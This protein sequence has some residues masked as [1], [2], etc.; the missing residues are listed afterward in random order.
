MSPF[1]EKEPGSAGRPV[2]RIGAKL[3]L[4]FVTLGLCLVLLELAARLLLPWSNPRVQI[5]YQRTT[6]GI[7]LGPRNQTVRL[8]TPKGDY[9]LLLHFNEDGFRD[10]KNLRE[11][12]E[13]DWFALGDSYTLGVGV[14][15]AERFSNLLEE[16]FKT[17]GPALSGAR[18]FNIAIPDNIIGYQRLLKYAE[19][20]IPALAGK[21]GVRHL[22][23]GVCMEND[24]W[25][26]HE[27]RSSWD[28]PLGADSPGAAADGAGAKRVPLRQWF[29]S[30]S[31]LYITASYELQKIPFLRR[32]LERSGIARN[33]EQ[34]AGQ[35]EWNETILTSSR[36][37][38]LKLVGGRDAFVLIV[39]S[40]LLWHGHNQETE[41]R[42]HE[43]FV[44]LLREAGVRVVDPKEALE[45]QGAPLDCYFKTDPHWNARGHA[46]ATR[47]L[48]E[49]IRSN[50]AAH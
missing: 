47:E 31:A 41:R 48:F 14:Q 36:D 29:K 21:G 8:A 43:T 49:A 32:W 20:R 26:Y 11:A 22:V 38:V 33:V 13:A 3:L 27:G 35:N 18:V 19:S 7:A 42:V 40:R 16:A 12:S 1:P 4:L 5:P 28:I 24:L 6:N 34:L 17:N 10:A 23:V 2:R 15:E 45:K 37:E 39:P 25:D 44:R 30:H 50:R 9:D 46:I